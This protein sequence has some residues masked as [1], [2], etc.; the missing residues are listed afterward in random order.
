MRVVRNLGAGVLI[1]A[2]FSPMQITAE[3]AG[4]STSALVNTILNGR[5]A[6]KS[7]IGIDGDF[8][9]DTRSL[10]I[11][12]P[13]RKGKWPAPQ[14]IQGPTGPSGNDGRNGSDGKTVSASN[15]N[16]V[17][18]PQGIQGAIGPVGPQGEKGEQ[19]LPGATGAAG[20]PG[21]SGSAGASG[22]NGA[23]G[24][25]GPMGPAGATGAKGETGT[26]GSSEV[27]YGQLVFN[28]LRGGIG[29]SEYVQLNIFESKKNYVVKI[30]INTYLP[31]D[32]TNSFL[33]LSLSVT[34]SI[35][36]AVV[37]TS[38]SLVNG[39]SYRNGSAYFENSIEAEVVLDGNSIDVSYGITILITAG[40]TTEV[41]GP[42]KISG[43]F[44]AIAVQ[45]ARIHA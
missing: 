38:Y 42:L 10:L 34:S 11:Y 7:S 19:G 31:N 1:L 18:G 43:S 36:G 6:P 41:N 33:P 45:S 12:G 5:G 30:H 17:V 15:V 8:Y 22:A 9:I 14:S 24:P 32:G 2:T 29:T 4:R 44:T 35:S 13:K 27:I 26:S 23:Q 20:V 16:T 39:A 37:Q 28:D 21:V 3:A 25:A 40:R